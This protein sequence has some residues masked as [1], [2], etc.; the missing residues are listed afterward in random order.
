MK[1]KQENDN[2]ICVDATDEEARHFEI[3][4]KG[5]KLQSRILYIEF[6]DDTLG[7]NENV[8]FY[9]EDRQRYEK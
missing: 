2:I 8:K 3:L 1:N 4:Y 6:I 5:R 7:E 9:L